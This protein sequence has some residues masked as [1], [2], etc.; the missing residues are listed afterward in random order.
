MPP[1]CNRLRRHHHADQH[2][3]VTCGRYLAYNALAEET[4]V[5]MTNSPHRAMAA[6]RRLPFIAIFDKCAGKCL[7]PVPFVTEWDEAGFKTN[8]V[9]AKSGQGTRHDNPTLNA[10]EIGLFDL[11]ADAAAQCGL[12]RR[13]GG[14]RA[15]QGSPRRPRRRHFLDRRL[16]R[17]FERRAARCFDQAGGREGSAADRRR[18]AGRGHRSQWRL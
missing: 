1:I 7:F 4:A 9:I 2:Q 12:R 15:H 5:F 10:Q 16:R 8:F 18:E 3:S 6:G 17:Q 14:G 11:S 13:S